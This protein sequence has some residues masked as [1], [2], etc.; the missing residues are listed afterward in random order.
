MSHISPTHELFNAV[1]KLSHDLGYDTYDHLPDGSASYP[2]VHIGEQF[3]Q[4]MTTNK[5]RL[6]GQTQITIHVWHNDWRRRSVLTEM[7]SDIERGLWGLRSTTRFSIRI[8]NT[9]KQVLTDTS[10]D[11]TLLHGILEVDISYQ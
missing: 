5:D 4:L 8:N 9:N 3:E 2:F 11:S 6:T 1:R 7:M 10:T